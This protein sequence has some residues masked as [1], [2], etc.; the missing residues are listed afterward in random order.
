VF[1]T[2]PRQLRRIGDA[3][4]C[5]G[6]SFVAFCMFSACASEVVGRSSLNSQQQQEPVPVNEA[7]DSEF[8]PTPDGSEAEDDASA[9]RS[10]DLASTDDAGMEGGIKE[11]NLDGGCTSS[12]T[13][14]QSNTCAVMLDRADCELLE[15]AGASAIVA[16]GQSA[17]VGTADCGGCGSVEVKVFYDGARCWQGIPDCVL[18][19]FAGN[20]FDPHAPG[21]IDAGVAQG[22]DADAG[23]GADAGTTAD[24]ADAGT[25]A[26]A[27]AGTPW[28]ADVGTDADTGAAADAASDVVADQ[29]D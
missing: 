5:T 2:E 22:A 13:E 26:D 25:G 12:C 10:D 17:A 7:G 4:L 20:F 23:T 9:G 8:A 3:L 6:V 24:A 1:P 28:D 18:P 15:F 29:G 14:N 27:D 21:A 16:C 19:Q 11:C